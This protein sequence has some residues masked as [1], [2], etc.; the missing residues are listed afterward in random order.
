[1]T[2]DVDL[3]ERVQV[4]CDVLAPSGFERSMRSMLLADWAQFETRE[5]ACGNVVARVGGSGPKILVETH[6]DEIGLLVKSVHDDGFLFA[7]QGASGSETSGPPAS[8]LRMQPVKVCGKSGWVDGVIGL[9]AGHVLTPAQSAK[10]RLDWSDLFVDIGCANRDQVIGLGI[11]IG[12]PIVFSTK[13]RRTGSNVVAKA[14]DARAGLAILTAIGCRLASRELDCELYLGA[15]VQEET[16]LVGAASLAREE[17]W[18][19]VIGLEVGLAGDIPCVDSSHMPTRLGGGPVI[20]RK[21]RQMVYDVG[22]SVGIGNFA[23]SI[24]MTIQHAIFHGFS[25]D[26]KCFADAGIRTALL[27]YPTR[28]THT[29]F[30]TASIPDLNSI[31]DLLVGLLGSGSLPRFELF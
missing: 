30:E 1:M 12:S 10:D 28:Y 29:P 15:T 14:L 26:L 21:D 2:E 17:K 11:G 25:S 8:W 3:I 6:M 13:S 31:A 7:T 16:S 24:G 5:T 23:D 9:A 27:A 20:V 19:Y 4:Y 18:D 22:L